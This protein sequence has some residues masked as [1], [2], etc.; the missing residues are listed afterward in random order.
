MGLSYNT[1]RNNIDHYLE[2][3]ENHAE[4]E[5]VYG[6]VIITKIYYPIYNKKLAYENDLLFLKEITE[7]NDGLSTLAGMARKYQDKFNKDISLKTIIRYFTQSRNKLFGEI[8]DK[9]QLKS[10][11]IAGSREYIWAIKLSN[12]NEY[13]FMTEEEEKLFNDITKEVYSKIEPKQIQQLHLAKEVY[14]EGGISKQQYE[15]YCHDNELNFF[16]NVILRFKEKTGL[17]IVC[18]N[19]YVVLMCYNLSNSDAEYRDRLF[20]ELQT[21][22]LF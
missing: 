4:F 9:K 17:Q 12:Y 19:R 11:G 21:I 13:R 6:G 8:Q 1:Y 18:A 15:D 16:E 7:C 2:K 22:E 14:N 3:L 20:K 10:Q 5:K